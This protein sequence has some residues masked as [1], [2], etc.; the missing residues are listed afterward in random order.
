[1]NQI[2]KQEAGGD[3]PP[4][5]EAGALI[6]IGRQAR[7]LVVRLHPRQEQAPGPM[8]DFEV[9]FDDNQ[10]ERDL[11]MVKLKQKISGRFGGDEGAESFCRIRWYVSTPIRRGAS[12]VEAQ[13]QACRGQPLTLSS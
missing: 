1:M 3:H 12:I 7:A 8:T 11:R 10:A 13:E 4:A 2:S 6:S 9:R 5:D